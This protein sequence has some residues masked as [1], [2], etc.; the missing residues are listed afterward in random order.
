MPMYESSE[1]KGFGSNYDPSAQPFF[2]ALVK[3]NLR[4]LMTL[5]SG[6]RLLRAIKDAKPANR[7][8]K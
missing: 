2:K 8:K 1:F 7:P 6:E 5:P 3:E 4:L